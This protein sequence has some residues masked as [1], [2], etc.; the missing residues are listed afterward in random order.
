MRSGLNVEKLPASVDGRDE[1]PETQ[2]SSTATVEIQITNLNSEVSISDPVPI[3]K[4][5]MYKTGCATTVRLI[6]GAA[7]H[8]TRVR[9][10]LWLYARQKRDLGQKSCGESM[11]TNTCDTKAIKQNAISDEER[12]TEHKQE[13]LTI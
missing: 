7:G 2:S 10:L 13:Q 4:P 9:L 3:D 11:C 6:V 5:V 8:Q 1:W 12:K